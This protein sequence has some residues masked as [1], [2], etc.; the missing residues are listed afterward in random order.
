MIIPKSTEKMKEN[1]EKIIMKEC[2]KMADD[3]KIVDSNI[4]QVGDRDS[5]GKAVFQTLKTTYV[6]FTKKHSNIDSIYKFSLKAPAFEFSLYLPAARSSFG[7]HIFATEIDGVLPC[8]IALVRSNLGA[9]G[10]GMWTTGDDEKDKMISSKLNEKKT[11]LQLKIA[12]DH[13]SGQYKQKLEWGVQLL[14][15]PFVKNKFLFLMQSGDMGFVGKKLGISHFVDGVTEVGAFIDSFDDS[16]LY[17][18]TESSKEFNAFFPSVVFK[19]ILA[20]WQTRNYNN[21]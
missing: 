9:F 7:P 10:F 2:S 18:N 21:S 12:W 14:H 6:P 15:V 4:I 20:G 13:A 16:Q 3:I 17:R 5:T 1:A 8:D 11:E 19:D